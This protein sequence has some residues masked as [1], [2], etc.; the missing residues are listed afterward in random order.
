MTVEEN[1]TRLTILS[2]TLENFMC[3]ESLKLTFNK[4][5]T[6]IAGTNGSGKSSVLTALGI[7]L[8]QRVN[9]LDRGPNLKS[10]IMSD[11]EFFC[12][13]LVIN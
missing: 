10:L 5:L 1:K 8:G 6:C 12:I 2:I 9:S 4:P 3:H 13:T 11:K 7:I